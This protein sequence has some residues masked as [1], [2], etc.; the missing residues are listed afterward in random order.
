[1]LILLKP[2]LKKILLNLL[3]LMTAK[4]SLKKS[5]IQNKTSK[6]CKISQHLIQA[7]VLKNPEENNKM[8]Q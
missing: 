4:Y 7:K 2:T 1:M 3:N 6:K 8:L 5:K